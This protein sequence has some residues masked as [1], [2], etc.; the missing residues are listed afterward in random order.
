MAVLHCTFSQWTFL[1]EMRAFRVGEA[2]NPGPSHFTI[3]AFNP[4]GLGTKQGVVAQLP[5]GL[6]AVCETHLSS[7][8][9]GD[10][11]LGL[12]LS[13]SSFS[14]LHGF[15]APLRVHSSVT[16][17]YT[18]VGFV[19]SY[20]GRVV[21]HAWPP[22]LYTTARAQVASFLVAD[23]WILGGVCY[24]FATDKARTSP[25]LDSVID[26]VLAQRSGPRFLAGDW[27]L[28]MHEL[29][30]LS[31]L[32]A[33]G[34]VEVQD[35]RAALT[36][37]VPEVTCK[38]CTRKDFLF[39]SPE[40]QAMFR[41]ACVDSTFFADHAVV[42]ASFQAAKDS[43]PRFV[44]RM[45]RRRPHVEAHPRNM[46][47]PLR[48]STV[49]SSMLATESDDP[50]ARFTSVCQAFE[51]AL[52]SAEVAAGRPP[53]SE[54]EKGRGRVQEVRCV[55]APVAP[56]RSARHG[57]AEPLY[58]GQ[59]L[60][61]AQW[62][63][64]LRRI[65]ALAQS[66]SRAS[67]SVTA[68]EHRSCLWRAILR[69]PGFAMPFR[70]WWLVREVVLVEDLP[71][72]PQACPAL[73]ECRL[74]FL[75]FEANLRAYERM[76]LGTRKAA[77]RKRREQDPSLIFRDLRAPRKAPV[78]TLLD[79]KEGEIIEVCADE[80]AIVLAEPVEWTPATL[81][82]VGHQPLHVVHAE[83]DKLWVES[84]EGLSPGATVKQNRLIGSLL[85]LFSEF[86]A[87][88]G[89]RWMRHES[90]DVDKWR[91][92]CSSFES[93]ARFPPLQLAPLS[94]GRWRA[95]LKAKSPK[96]AAG[97][98][99]LSRADLLSFPDSL[100][101]QLLALCAVAEDTGRWPPQVLE[102]IVTS[103]EKTPMAEAVSDYRPICVLSLVYRVWAS[104]RAKEALAHLAKHAPP[105]LLG[106][107]P[108]VASADVW[109]SIQVQIEQAYR[110]G[111]GLHGASA[112]LV[113]AFNMLPRIP[114][115]AFARVCG[116]PQQLLRPW[117]AALTGLRRRFRVRGS[118]GPSILSSTGFAE[119]DALSC[120]AMAVVNVAFHFAVQRAPG[121]GRALTYV[122]NWEMIA[123]DV[124][125]LL[126]T[127]TAMEAF[128]QAWDLPVDGAKTVAWSTTAEGRSA[129]KASGFAVALDFR[130]LGAHLQASRRRS[131]YTQTA[132]IRS[133]EDKWPR[134]E[135]SLAPF[136]Q[137]VRALSVAAWPAALHGISV[138]Q[139]GEAHFTNLRSAAMKGLGLR[140]PGANPMLQL[141]L[142]E[143]PTAD[144]FFFALSVSFSDMKALI[145]R[146][147]GAPLLTQAADS[148][149]HAPG[150]AG[151][152]LDRANSVAIAWNRAS[153][154]FEDIF[155]AFCLWETSLPEVQARLVRAWQDAVQHKL[156]HRASFAGLEQADPQLTGRLVRAF[157][158]PEQA[159][160]RLSLH[161]A[162]YTND[163]LCHTGND[164]DP[165]CQFC[166]CPDSI[167]H[168]LL[169]CSHF[170]CCRVDMPLS[171]AQL[172]A[173]PDAQ[174]LHG[175]AMRSPL[176]L[177]VK[178]LLAATVQD[179]TNFE[180]V[181]EMDAY[182]LF[183]D[184]SC[185]R[186][187][188]PQLRLAAWAVNVALPGLPARSLPLGCG[189]V[190]GLLQSSFRGELCAALAAVRFCQQCRRPVRIWSDCQGV[191]SRL[192]RLLSS[193]WFPRTRSP[194]AD[195]W[196]QFLPAVEEIG[197]L[198]HV[199][200]V[201]SHLDPTLEQTFGDEWC[202][203]QNDVADRAATA[204]HF[205]RSA[206]FWQVWRTFE[207]AYDKQVSVSTAV[208]QLHARVGLRA[209]TTK[210]Q[211]PDVEPTQL[212]ID[213]GVISVLGEL[214]EHASAAL[215]LRYG[216]RFTASLQRWM[217]ASRQGPFARRWIS[218][219]QLYFSF[220]LFSACPVPVWKE[221]RWI[222]TDS[223]E[224][225]AF[226]EVPLSKRLRHWTQIL[227]AA[228]RQGGYSWQVQETRPHSTSLQVRRTSVLLDF[229][230]F[231]YESVER[232]LLEKLPQRGASRHQRSWLTIPVPVGDC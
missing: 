3:G 125:S 212:P 55:R 185:L 224:N 16:G 191:V 140:A 203:E 48:A 12:R 94:V 106:N 231:L 189:L 132:R 119:G 67:P 227:R 76:L 188:T 77:A 137:K 218:T 180:P 208:L 186:P 176:E 215:A 43:I 78:E 37:V 121:V 164:A 25:L 190:P 153:G 158:P 59:N 112:D 63:R 2:A 71:A 70:E 179:F 8:G 206:A 207:T 144:P 84:L 228:A 28:E 99:G 40:L 229:P 173:L 225:G 31:R 128:T 21:A 108:G 147:I 204:A 68:L 22:E 101:E 146:E 162:F 103:L 35:L 57:D 19:S 210:P 29:P 221:G 1:C 30:Q 148:M 175:W 46:P 223:V 95:E 7:R 93:T 34:F 182:D 178:R 24:G 120:V 151:V 152:L 141:S 216:A 159:L 105:G 198:I 81:F 114:V 226:V 82:Y 20:P 6:Y 130:D 27:N 138:V 217:A 139:L 4:T 184:G 64:Q 66:L 177:Q 154:C 38:G 230:D 96:G 123:G 167:R 155:G 10:F 17:S 187:E 200:K 117:M 23:L 181:P 160:L 124:P 36:G 143:F 222:C 196:C 45:P 41:Q 214:G 42:S 69:A 219:V 127:H 201:V 126:A 174:L 53:L 166:G 73:A 39:I 33:H 100:T 11:R 32:R 60:R 194:H 83:P 89:R 15:P 136:A 211:R 26:R 170:E 18:G 149:L 65:Q 54:A 131:N 47:S 122:D 74:L 79:R 104:L 145:G 87:Q 102:G 62:F 86:G 56:V 193:G 195:L 111:T 58:F 13:G 135:A 5:P 192:R 118:V 97:P 50:A 209:T 156:C 98:D 90:V 109:F 232:Y 142:V 61:Y 157:P 220:C 80:N 205:L 134:L 171:P 110:A 172:A 91:E 199:H 115:M 92:L 213:D 169:H 133:L 14:L 85:E 49:R 51:L 88:W 107:L 183:T 168:R 44:W 52:S 72:L 165:S 202:A 116:L 197:H 161:G 113:K 150:P 163:R 75:S 9:V 129:L